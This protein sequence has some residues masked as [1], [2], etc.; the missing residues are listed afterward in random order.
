MKYQDE[1]VNRR[2]F[3]GVFSK[4]QNGLGPIYFRGNFKNNVDYKHNKFLVICYKEA[5]EKREKKEANYICN[6]YMIIFVILPFSVF[7]PTKHN[8]NIKKSFNLCKYLFSKMKT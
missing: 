5:K 3:P 4:N 6:I 1:H 7:D 2:S 8:L